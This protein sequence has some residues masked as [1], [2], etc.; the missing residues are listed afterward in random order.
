MPVSFEELLSKGTVFR[1]KNILSPHYVPEQLPYREDEI[2]KIMQA[3]APAIQGGKP[4]NLFV[5]GVTGSG[6]TCCTKYVLKRLA[7]QRSSFARTAYMNCRIYDTRYKIIQKCISEYEPDFARTGYS[8]AIIYEKILDW[9]EG[10]IKGSDQTK[11]KQLIVV[12]DEIDLVKDLD[13]LLY[14]L[15]RANDDLRSGGVSVIGISNRI[16]FTNRL[17]TRS[18]SSLCEEE[19]VFQ[20]YNAEQLSGILR[21]R[22][23]TAFNDGVIQE[24]AVSLA[25]AIA[26]GENG[27]ARYALSLLLRAGEAAEQR[28][29]VVSDREVE[30]ARKSADEDR[31]NE[32][33]GSLPEHQQLVLYSLATLASDLEYKKLVEDSGEKYYFSGEVYERYC[34]L[35]KKS[36]RE[37]RTSRWYREYL[38]E[39]ESLGLLTS[40]TS[41]KGV[42]GHAT[43]IKL[44]YE[45]SKVKKIIEKKLLAE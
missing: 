6:K 33:I 7:E 37:P 43:L 12:L 14:T 38:H 3:V 5:Y 2:R 22:A 16:S 23:N 15:T 44:G 4:K 1:D 25:A 41:G 34:R 26:A 42:R 28:N 8:F 27:D 17:D 11:G 39:L 10:E 35:A 13:S 19:L 31:A 9:L 30:F 24:G 36:G 20:P 18:K 40:I 29:S 32:V 21:E 45:P